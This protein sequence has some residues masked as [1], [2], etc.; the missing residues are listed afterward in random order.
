MFRSQTKPNDS[1]IDTPCLRIFSTTIL[2]ILTIGADFECLE[3]VCYGAYNAESN[4]TSPGRLSRQFGYY[5]SINGRNRILE[6]NWTV[7][8][9][10][11]LLPIA[12]PCLVLLL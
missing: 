11:L 2:C 8:G 9:I 4:T 10:E 3:M 5:I 7:D 6:R 12:W 1:Q